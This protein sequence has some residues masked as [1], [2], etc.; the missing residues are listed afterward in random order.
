MALT[1]IDRNVVTK[2]ETWVLAYLRLRVAASE[3]ST[4]NRQGPVLADGSPHDL[5]TAAFDRPLRITAR[6]VRRTLT[7][8]PR[9]SL[10]GFHTFRR[11]FLFTP[12]A[13]TVQIFIPTM[14]TFDRSQLVIETRERFAA[15]C[16]VRNRNDSPA[17]SALTQPAY[18]NLARHHLLRR[19]DID[20]AQWG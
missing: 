5:R 13:P 9:S 10:S 15:R 11:V 14:W 16:C 3:R 19:P 6:V 17:R 12:G 7:G 2:R 4:P 1:K 8:A 18:V 20:V